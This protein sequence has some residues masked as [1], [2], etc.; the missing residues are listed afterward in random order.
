VDLGSGEPVGFEALARWR[1]EGKV[2]QPNS[3][4]P[5]CAETG[6]TGDL[7]LLIIE[8]TLAALPL[9]A[10]PIPQRPMT[11]NV[12]LSGVLLEDRDLR[13]RLL[14]LVDDN[15]LPPGW[16]LQMELV[17]DAFQD[18]SAAFD[19]FLNDLV[20]RGV[21]IAIDDFGTGYS[22]FA[23]LISLP[24][25]S[26]KVDRTFV[27]RIAGSDDSPRL[28]LR[29]MLTM[30]NDLGMAVTAE[31]IEQPAQRDW[32]IHHGVTKGQGYL[33]AMPLTLTEAVAKLRSI[34]YRPRAI[35]VEP[36]RIWA[37]RR[38]RWLRHLLIKPLAGVL[39]RDDRRRDV[40]P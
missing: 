19:H 25:Q 39:G 9:L 38:R 31:G 29:T 4:L 5:I 16:S 20:S 14:R 12:N 22:S 15:Q 28:V 1:Y 37:A 23:R 6:L 36:A 3:F 27:D 24:I 21:S 32:L 18:T 40:E 34:H 10:Q 2:L 13:Q 26:V 7:D 11:I 30:L 35:P 33:F 8:K 17:E